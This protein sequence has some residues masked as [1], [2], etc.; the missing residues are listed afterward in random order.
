VIGILGP[1]CCTVIFFEGNKMFMGIGLFDHAILLP[2]F[3]AAWNLAVG[4][5]LF[6]SPKDTGRAFLSPDGS[7]TV[8]A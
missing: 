2:A 8:M 1:E 6:A 5:T 3:A 4:Q 7:F